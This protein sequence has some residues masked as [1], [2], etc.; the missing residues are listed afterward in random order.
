MAE[1]KAEAPVQEEKK[2]S[3]GMM[4]LFGGLFLGALIAG[5]IVWWL[6]GD[7]SDSDDPDSDVQEESAGKLAGNTSIKKLED[8]NVNLRDPSGAKKLQMVISL[9]VKPTV[10]KELE[11]NEKIDAIR[12]SIIMFSSEFTVEN[13]DGLDGKMGLRD[14][15]ELRINTVLAPQK[16]ERVYFTKF[17]Y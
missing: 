2:R 8:F 14:G 4:L 6:M 16:V 15:I 12:D 5:G 10:A 7:K 17:I 9:E 3:N 1:E 13:L 11:K